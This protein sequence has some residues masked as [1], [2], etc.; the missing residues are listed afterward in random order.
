MNRKELEQ[1][2]AEKASRIDDIIATLSA[3]KGERYAKAAAM[4]A[5]VINAF[6]VA[7]C[8][9][10]ST[11]MHFTQPTL[12]LGATAAG[13]DITDAALRTAFSKD[14]MTFCTASFVVLPGTPEL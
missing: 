8:G 12:T 11:V 2:I 3:V 10:I 1:F 9:D 5:D 13:I 7:G 4:T 14:V 6:K